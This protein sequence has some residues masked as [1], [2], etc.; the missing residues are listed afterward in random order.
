MHS[1]RL[2]QHHHRL[3]YQNVRDAQGYLGGMQEPIHK[4]LMEEL[5]PELGRD[6]V[7]PEEASG[8]VMEEQ[9]RNQNN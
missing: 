3:W 1:S 2:D 9:K 6:V 7:H 4:F 8:T 5:D